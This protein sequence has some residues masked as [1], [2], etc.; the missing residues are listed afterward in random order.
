MPKT[1]P[2]AVKRRYL[3]LRRNGFSQRMAMEQV[4]VKSPQTAHKW[5]Q[6]LPQG[7][8]NVRQLDAQDR[9]PDPIPYAGLKPDAKRAHDDFS[10]FSERYLCRE[11]VPWRQEAADDLVVALANKNAKDFFGI[12]CPPSAGKTSLDLD[13]ALWCLIRNRSIRILL[14]AEVLNV[15][16]G[17]LRFV[18]D[19]LTATAPFRDREGH[20]AAGVLP[21]DFGRLQPSSAAGDVIM[22]RDDAFIV[23]Q[24]GGDA[25]WSK[26]PSVQIA[27]QTRGSS[28]TGSISCCGTTCSRSG[29]TAMAVW[30]RGGDAKRKAVSIPVECWP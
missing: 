6:M 15:A 26:E 17:Y 23:A 4:G 30:H 10:F 22:W 1:H 13:L 14:G 16:A 25:V 19:R 29:T 9:V 24:L 11:P 2:P 5:D 21:L 12:C 3:N 27:S 28:E 18:K 7:V 20:T 8:T